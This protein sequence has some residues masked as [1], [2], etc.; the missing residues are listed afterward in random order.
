MY[1]IRLARSY[2]LLL[3]DY[4]KKMSVV[5]AYVKLAVDLESKDHTVK[6]D[7]DLK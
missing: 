1:F 7:L 6:I 2:A 5:F 3:I 4:H